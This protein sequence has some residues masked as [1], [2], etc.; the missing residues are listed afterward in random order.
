VKILKLKIAA[1]VMIAF[2]TCSETSH[3]FAPVAI[4]AWYLGTA[5]VTAVTAGGLYYALKSGYAPHLDVNGTVSRA[6]GVAYV[7]LNSITKLPEVIEKGLVASLSFAQMKAAA[8]AKPSTY[9][10]VKAAL[11][12]TGVEYNN[13]PSS[14]QSGTVMNV[15]GTY[16][17]ASAAPVY[18]DGGGQ[19]WCALLSPSTSIAWSSYYNKVYIIAPGA[20][21]N[22]YGNASRWYTVNASVVSNPA[23]TTRDATLFETVATIQTSPSDTTVKTAYQSELDAMVKD[24]A[25][26]PT[27]S[28]DTT[29]LPF[30][31]PSGVLSPAKVEAYNQAGVAA[32]KRDAALAAANAAVATAQSAYD[33]AV[34]NLNQNPSDP[35]LIA[36]ANAAKL[37]L[38]KAKTNAAG[39]EAVNATTAA[40]EAEKTAETETASG[41]TLPAIHTFSW[42]ALESLKGVMVSTFPF[43]LIPRIGSLYSQIVP[44]DPVA[45]SFSLP[46]FGNMYSVSLAMFDPLAAAIRSF[47]AVAASAAAIVAMVKFYRGV[48]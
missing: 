13:S 19:T 8:L 34:T 16:Y 30:A 36:A 20:T 32:D 28:D 37:E 10:N 17:R 3:A 23:T 43:Y 5:A 29:G 26:V 42:A 38:D 33:T 40:G 9:P 41:I 12:W 24:S 48:S 45:P 25:Y 46:V 18:T 6:A 35:S 15:G 39:I 4:P 2:F 7:T 27:F 22:S 44:E 47:I 1:L 11:Q 31:Y 21:Y 14:I